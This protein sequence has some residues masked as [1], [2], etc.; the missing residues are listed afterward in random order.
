M[1]LF[2]RG[3]ILSS[4]GDILHDSPFSVTFLL[5]HWPPRLW[6]FSHLLHVATAATVK[7]YLGSTHTVNSN[8]VSL[9]I[10]HYLLDNHLSTLTIPIFEFLLADFLRLSIHQCQLFHTT[11]CL[12]FILNCSHSNFISWNK[13]LLYCH[14]LSKASI[15]LYYLILLL[16]LQQRKQVILSDCDW[17]SNCCT[18]IS[19]KALTTCKTW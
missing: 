17:L 9:H 15:R 13:S 3:D 8:H 11:D 4:S 14:P 7:L 10:L 18:F 1:I 6:F 19:S 12:T 5:F 2:V 16:Q